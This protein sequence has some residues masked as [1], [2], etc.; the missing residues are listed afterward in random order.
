MS[1]IER[2]I[3]RA[4]QLARNG[5]VKIHRFYPSGRAI[6]TVVGRE[7]E[8]IIDP[9]KMVCSC[10]DFFYRVL[11]KKDE[12]CYHLLAYKIAEQERNIEVIEFSDDEYFQFLRALLKDLLNP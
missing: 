4:R 2:K 12:K 8:E 11:R 10:K 3:E 5:S 9:K 7:S 6:H 1:M